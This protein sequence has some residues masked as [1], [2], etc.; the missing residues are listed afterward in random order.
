LQDKKLFRIGG[1]K[2]VISDFRL[3]AATNRNL[4]EDVSAGR[5]RED[6]YYRLNVMSLTIPPLRQ[7]KEDIA[8]LARFYIAK[9]A[10]RYAHPGIGLSA[11]NERKLMAYDWPGNVRELK[12]LIERAV[13]LWTGGQLTIDIPLGEKT[14]IGNLYHDLPT[15]D[16]MQRRYISYILEITGGRI[17]GPGGAAERLGIKRTTLNNRM[18]ILGLR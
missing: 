3:V 5:F 6:L 1:T 13:L 11:D 7:R 15:F 2:P 9:Y 17:G 12:N 8:R 16:E 18:K 14:S 10:A 4:A